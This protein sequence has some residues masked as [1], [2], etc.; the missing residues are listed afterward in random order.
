MSVFFDYFNIK[1]NSNANNRLY[2]INSSV[3][4]N[5]YIGNENDYLTSTKIQQKIDELVPFVND[6][7]T[8]Y[9]SKSMN[10]MDYNFDRLIINRVFKNINST[11]RINYNNII[12]NPPKTIPNLK[13][14]YDPSI[15]TSPSSAQNSYIKCHMNYLYTHKIYSD[16]NKELY[17][18]K[19]EAD[20]LINGIDTN[21]TFNWLKT[22]VYDNFY[23]N[24][25]SNYRKYINNYDTMLIGEKS[26]PTIELINKYS[27]GNLTDNE[28]LCNVRAALLTSSYKNMS[29]VIKNSI[30]D[31]TKYPNLSQYYFNAD[32]ISNY[33]NTELFM[34]LN[35]ILNNPSVCGETQ[36]L[37][38]IVNMREGFTGKMI[39]GFAT[40][41]NLNIY[42]GNETNYTDFLNK[43]S[44]KEK[45]NEYNS[46][47]Q[48][49]KDGRGLDIKTDGGVI[50]CNTEGLGYKPI[51]FDMY[52]TCSN[53][54]EGQNGIQRTINAET[55]EQLSLNSKCKD[56][57]SDSNCLCS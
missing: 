39:E 1:D 2:N 38:T 50:Q 52:Y 17:N 44:Y 6:Y 43:L 49:L 25:G 18:I 57:N 34:K 16:V 20:E 37:G 23:K 11:S 35:T 46:A 47:E 3:Y 15:L 9:S 31:N 40:S 27:S 29:D 53:T 28:K 36:T 32:I 51:N 12:T 13:I 54:D 14:F 45:G 30:N 21:I 8:K 42:D 5:H 19:I 4:K 26:I 7:Y 22:N 55:N 48:F 41:G 10:Y 56:I 33:I 24:T